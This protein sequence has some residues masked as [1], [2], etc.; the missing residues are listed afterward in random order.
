MNQTCPK[1]N[2][3]VDNSGY[4]EVEIIIEA[5]G[6]EYK[7]LV[8]SLIF[9]F[10]NEHNYRPC[11]DFMDAVRLGNLI[12]SIR[13]RTN[14]REKPKAYLVW[15]SSKG[16]HPIGFDTEGSKEG[17]VQDGFIVKLKRIMEESETGVGEI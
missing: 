5:H 17:E 6:H 14:G 7:Y 9:H 13:V 15:Y 11:P 8:H 4:G 12:E 2:M 16:Y 3:A 10:I 1:C